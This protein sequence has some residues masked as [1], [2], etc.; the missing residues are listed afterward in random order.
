MSSDFM[1]NTRDHNSILKEWLDLNKVFE[2]VEDAFF[3]SNNLWAA[4]GPV[5]IDRTAFFKN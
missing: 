5:I 1:G 2:V 4:G 3:L